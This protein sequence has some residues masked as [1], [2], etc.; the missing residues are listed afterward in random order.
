MEMYIPFHI[1]NILKALL[2]QVSLLLTS[3][4]SKS[5]FETLTHINIHNHPESPNFRL[6]EIPYHVLQNPKRCNFMQQTM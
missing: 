6:H 3:A 4:K 5:D 1:R 2:S